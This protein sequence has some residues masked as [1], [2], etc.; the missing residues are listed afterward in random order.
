VIG[1]ALQV[2]AIIATI[3]KL[4]FHTSIYTLS[5]PINTRSPAVLMIRVAM[6]T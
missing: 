1:F 6:A 5:E 2:Q 3:W 4:N